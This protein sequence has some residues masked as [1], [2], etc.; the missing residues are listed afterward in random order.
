MSGFT[1]LRDPDPDPNSTRPPKVRPA[2]LQKLAIVYVRQSSLEQ[3]RDYTGSTAA[4][5]ELA[6]LPHRWGWPESRIQV[7]DA[8][9]GLSAASGSKRAGFEQMLDLIERDEVG[10]VFVRDISRLSRNPLEAVRFIQSTK[11]HRTLIYANG[12]VR[13]PATDDLSAL[14]GLQLEGLL[15]WY[16]NATRT[17]SFMAAR[18]AKARQGHA[19]SPPPIGYVRSVQG[20]W[21]KDPDLEVQETIR[22]VFEL[23]PKLLSLGNIVKY[24]RQHNLLFPRRRH[25]QV[26]WGPANATRLHN[27]LTNPAYTGDYVF[28]R[29]QTKAGSGSGAPRP[30]RRPQADWIRVKDHHEPYVARE[31]WHRIQAALASQRPAMRPLVGKG[32]ALLQGLLR[33]DSCHRWMSTKYWGR[34]GEART[35]TYMCRQRNGWGDVTHSVKFPARIVDQAVIHQVLGALTPVEIK[36][37]L[38]AIESA[39]AEQSALEKARRRQLQRAEDEVE[40]ARQAYLSV[41][42]HPRVRVDLEAKYDETLARYERLRTE[43]ASTPSPAANLTD[44]DATELLD[45]TRDAQRLWLASTTTNED[46]KRL[47]RAVISEV[48]VR[49]A[50]REVVDLEIIWTGGLQQACQALRPQGVDS[51]VRAQTEAGKDAGT[52]TDELRQAGVITTRGRLMSLNVIHQKLGHLGLREKRDRMAALQLIRQALLEGRPRHEILALLRA[53]ASPRLGS[54]TPQRLSDTIRQL[55]KGIVGIEPLPHALPEDLEAQRVLKVIEDGQQA[56]EGWTALAAKLN[57]LG[58]KPQRARAFAAVQVRT[59][60]LRALERKSSPKGGS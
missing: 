33:C 58:L 1:D 49:R 57:A 52:I 50:T 51:L 36:T 45:L 42:K 25:G 6:D 48:I 31:D 23:Y 32:S 5:R 41:R 19:V 22:R 39:Q 40:A 24:M 10:I 53:Q 26:K 59:L 30:K 3:V 55:R 12:G 17:R 28:L 38:D 21:V 16:E 46:R 13:D 4:Q 8:D 29:Y 9:L 11:N 18:I 47:L 35:A 34:D 15:A 37:A 44:A 43:V 56:G 54:W 60:Y 27:T 7:I 2:H 20:H 14:F